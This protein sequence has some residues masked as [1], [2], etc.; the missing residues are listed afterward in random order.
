MTNR[1]P[2]NKINQSVKSRPSKMT[3]APSSNPKTINLAIT[4]GEL[5]KKSRLAARYS[6]SEYS[7]SS[8]TSGCDIVNSSDLTL[9]DGKKSG[10]NSPHRSSGGGTAVLL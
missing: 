7:Y 10:S 1:S 5:K 9:L 6:G 8:L 2:G 3:A 4:F